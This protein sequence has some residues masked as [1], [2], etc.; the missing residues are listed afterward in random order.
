MSTTETGKHIP[1]LLEMHDEDYLNQLYMEK[2]HKR[3]FDFNNPDTLEIL[4]KLFKVIPR[5]ILIPYLRNHTCLNR[6]Y[7]LG[8]SESSI[9]MYVADLSNKTDHRDLFQMLVNLGANIDLQD[10]QGN[11]LLMRK[12]QSIDWTIYWFNKL[13]KIGANINIQNADGNTVLFCVLN[14]RFKTHNM[15]IYG[16]EKTIDVFN[17]LITTPNI[18]PNLQN[19]KGDTLLMY[20]IRKCIQ[21]IYKKFDKDIKKQ[22]QILNWIDT[23]LHIHYQFDNFAGINLQGTQKNTLLLTLLMQL[24]SNTYTDLFPIIKKIII[25]YKPNLDIPNE[26]GYTV[27]YHALK[28][29][30]SKLVYL[31]LLNS[32]NPFLYYSKNNDSLIY[33]MYS[34]SS[35]IY[36]ANNLFKIKQ[37]NKFY[38]VH[39]ILECINIIIKFGGNINY[40]NKKGKS[41]YMLLDIFEQQK[42]LK[43]AKY[44]ANKVRNI[45]KYW[46]LSLLNTCT[47]YICV[48]TYLEI[49]EFEH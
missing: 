28:Y 30:C 41:F 4:V 37:I 3:I 49:D 24:N 16:M 2:L 34:T 27:L 1:T 17:T 21:F 14:D 48:K 29:K 33:N 39:D 25:N 43:V 10:T 12:A 6:L 44:I 36:H 19:K 7:R 20:I 11:T 46:K 31:L 18:N 15:Y 9:L 38:S 23:M 26:A 13:I 35:H 45:D 22:K 32:A 8:Y 47:R 5:D 42:G 40:K